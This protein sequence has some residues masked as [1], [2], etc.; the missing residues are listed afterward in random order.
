MLKLIVHADDF[1][2]SQRINEGIRQAHCEGILT[3]TSLMAN[4]AE[5][6]HAIEIC[7]E[8]PTLDVGVHL[9]L[10]EE[11]PILGAHTVPSLV[12]P[13]GKFHRHATILTK[14]YLRGKVCLDQ[15]RLELDAQIRK[16]VSHGVRVTHLDGHQHAHM[17]PQI[18]RITV[19]LARQY[20]IPYVRYPSERLGLYMLK[21]KGAI[22]R[23]LQLLA[24]NFLS[25]LGRSA[26]VQRTDHFVGFYFGGRL[27]KG[28][29]LKVIE[30]L[31]RTGTCELM[32][33]PGADDP[34]TT[35]AHWGYRWPDELHAL[36]DQEVT[37]SLRRRAVQ[38]ISYRELSGS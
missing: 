2:L 1:G 32:C 31:P 11:R 19:D 34:E 9:T 15:V 36:L 25:L 17:L 8:M 38:L 3:S 21:E 22:A 30:H 23:T 20:G 10:V 37:D 6:N 28:N 24:L 18:L 12:D 29:L 33:H 27:N 35:H 5:F 16:V 13:D 26:S 7:R 14:H 4:G